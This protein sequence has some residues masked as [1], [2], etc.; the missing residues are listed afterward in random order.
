MTEPA[1]VNVPVAPL[2]RALDRVSNFVVGV[3]AVALLGLVVVQGWQVFT[4]YV[5]NDSPSWT[6]PVTLLLLSTALSLAAAAGVHTNR[7]FG[8]YLL[9]EHMPPL[10][11]RVFD[12]IR[13]VMIIAIGAVLAWWSAVLLLD[14]LDIKMAGAQ[15][16]QSINYLPLSIG[17]ALMVV[18]ALY[19]LW[20]VLRPIHTG[21][22]R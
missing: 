9:G 4:R 13:P 8:F 22:V 19:K 11:R 12:V 5:L 18:F 1:S 7:H 10:V 14:G 17:G 3:A 6:E 15:M 16:P 2:Q 21:G 20:R